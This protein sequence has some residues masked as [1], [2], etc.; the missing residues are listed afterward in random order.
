MSAGY[1]PSMH[2]PA[3]NGVTLLYE[4]R[5]VIVGSIRLAPDHPNY[6]RAAAAHV[7]PSVAFPRVP[8]GIHHSDRG[9]VIGDAATAVLFNVGEEYQRRALDPRGTC[10]DWIEI[11][12]ELARQIVA[13]HDPAPAD[14]PRRPFA[15]G[16]SP[17]PA[18]AFS[19][20]RLNNR[21]LA[22]TRDCDPLRIEE[23]SVRYVSDVIAAGYAARGAGRRRR[24]SEPCARFQRDAVESIRLIVNTRMAEKLTLSEIGR[25]VHMS[26]FHMCRVFRRLTGSPIHRYR[27]HLRVRRAMELLEDPAQRTADIALTVGFSS[28][29]HLSD[30]F[31]RETGTRPS[32]FRREISTR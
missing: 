22:R 25:M 5:S 12:P 17:I 6:R 2:L 24:A 21:R 20:Q 26:E 11:A 13:A 3:D 29:S 8:V 28:E 19:G 7:W 31:L 18:Q 15:F 16:S 23:E 32:R 9:S 4:G 14:D 30:A 27:D 10:N 1:V